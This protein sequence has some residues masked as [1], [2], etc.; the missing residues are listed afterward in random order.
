MDTEVAKDTKVPVPLPMEVNTEIKK[1]AEVKKETKVPVSLPT[2]PHMI[3][4]KDPAQIQCTNCHQQITTRV[5]SSVSS[6][7]WVFACCCC[8]FG[9]CLTSLLVKT[10]YVCP[11]RYVS[12]CSILGVLSPGLP[13]VLPLLPPV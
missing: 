1:N 8:L 6:D 13:G 12:K 9:S 3:F 4:G 2:E 5:E 7:G 10:Y 11:K